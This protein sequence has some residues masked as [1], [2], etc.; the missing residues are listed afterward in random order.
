MV[1]IQVLRYRPLL[2]MPGAFAYVLE[3]A[4]VLIVY[5]VIILWATASNVTLLRTALI[6]GTPVGL[7]ASALQ[8]AH[9]VTED[10]FHI[11][12]PWAAILAV[13]SMLST[14]LLWGVAGYRSARMSG[15]IVQ[16]TV[17]GSWSAIV[18]MCVVVVFGFA[19]EFYWVPPTPEYVA[20]WA[21]FIRSGW[22]D[23]HAFA[24]ANTFDSALS[25][26]VLGP[27]IGAVF[28]GIGSLVAKVRV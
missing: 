21:E 8:I 2:E 22:T 26:L 1:A 19:L 25:H 20:T 27:I 3:T 12:S 14:F 18:A 23:A 7:V 15:A 6:V 16:R 9:L 11:E 10:L 5:G 13:S 24:I 28:G 17:A 4:L